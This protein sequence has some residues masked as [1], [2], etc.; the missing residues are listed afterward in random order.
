MTIASGSAEGTVRI[1]VLASGRGSNFEALCSGDTGRGRVALLITD[2]PGAQVLK[3]AERLGVEAVY[4][5]PGRYRTRF[6]IEEEGEWVSFMRSR[7]VGLVCLAG[8]MRILKGPILEEYGGR[9]MNIHPSL[10]PSFPGLDAQDQALRY[11]V[12]VSGCTVHYADDGVDTGPVIVQRVVPVMDYDDVESLSA[13]I[14][15]QE[16]LAYPEAVRLHCSGRLAVRGRRVE[17]CTGS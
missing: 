4:M 3:K 17:T 15:E 1:A 6:G 16:H 10:L 8:L 12:K 2:N 14:L 5:T 9:V 7:G 13:R 11:G